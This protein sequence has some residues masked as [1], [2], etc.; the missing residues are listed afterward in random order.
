MNQKDAMVAGAVTALVASSRDYRYRDEDDRRAALRQSDD[1][2]GLAR[3]ANASI[4][5]LVD[6][7]DI[8]RI[9]VD[10]V[11]DLLVGLSYG[12]NQEDAPASSLPSTPSVF[13]RPVIPESLAVAPQQWPPSANEYDKTGKII[14][15]ADWLDGQNAL[16][17]LLLGFAETRAFL[18][19][20][21]R[22]VHPTS[23]IQAQIF[24]AARGFSNAMESAAGLTTRLTQAQYDAAWARVFGLTAGPYAPGVIYAQTGDGAPL[25]NST[26]E[27]E[28]AEVPWPHG[29]LTNVGDVAEVIF[30]GTVA[31]NSTMTGRIRLDISGGNSALAQL[32]MAVTTTTTKQ[33]RLV[34]TR[35][36]D[37]AGNEVY[38]CAS[39]NSDAAVTD[40]VTIVPGE[41]SQ[42]RVERSVGR[43]RNG[44]HRDRQDRGSPQVLRPDG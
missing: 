31:G 15:S 19:G 33:Q 21:A 16:T 40:I 37:V 14:H 27:T 6:N 22:T 10:T 44:Q 13:S 12:G 38:E 34:I 5:A 28:L 2:L 1:A 7:G 39:D 18:A 11:S 17:G 24:R 23:F 25:A 42:A 8:V 30:G 36:A 32:A 20:L 35:R 43:C 3:S 41:R 9:S 26:T 4:Q 29:L